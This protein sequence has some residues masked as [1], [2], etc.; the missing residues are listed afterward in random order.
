MITAST[1]GSARSIAPS[2]DSSASRFWGGTATPVG[3]TVMAPSLLFDD[4]GLDGCRHA[5]GHLDLDHVSA[6]FPDRL[7]EPHLA[8]IDLETACLAHGVRDLLRRDRAEQLAIL[9]CTVR[10]RQHR[11]REKRRGL[12][13]PLL[14]LTRRELGMLLLAPGGRD[15]G[16]RRALGEPAWGGG[17]PGGAR[18]GFD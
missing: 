1:A 13:R 3:V 14:L 8:V 2:T 6:Q 18:R 11:L 10:N 9:P 15:R 4:H 12:L 5:L 16:G 7:L 17:G